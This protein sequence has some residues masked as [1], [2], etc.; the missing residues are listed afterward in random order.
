MPNL[1]KIFWQSIKY[2]LRGVDEQIVEFFAYF[3]SFALKPEQA[4]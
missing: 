2:T 1:L 3:F 4:K